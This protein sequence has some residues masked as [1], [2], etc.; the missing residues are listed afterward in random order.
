MWS[1]KRSGVQSAL[2]IDLFA[3]HLR[4]KQ[5]LALRKSA[6]DPCEFRNL[7]NFVILPSA[8]GWFSDRVAPSSPCMQ[9]HRDTPRIVLRLCRRKLVARCLVKS[10]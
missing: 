10:S 9:I 7:F 6:I 1:A 4:D 8:K 3:R 2:D 5:P